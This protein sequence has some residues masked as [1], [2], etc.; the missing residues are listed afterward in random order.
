MSWKPRSMCPLDC[1]FPYRRSAGG[2]CVRQGASGLVSPQHPTMSSTP[3][4][5][6]L[7]ILTKETDAEEIHAPCVRLRTGHLLSP[8]LAPICASQKS[9]S[10]F[11]LTKRERDVLA[12]VAAGRRT[13]H[14][15][16][17]VQSPSPLSTHISNASGT[18][19]EPAGSRAQNLA[20]RWES[21]RRIPAIRSE[22][23]DGPSNH[24]A[25]NKY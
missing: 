20:H 21:D 11:A 10:A 9:T 16:A 23:G 4:L 15:L 5:P 8:T 7:P 14:R 17:A 22:R 3:S 6:E 24:E 18:R 19:R 12:L 13:R 25:P 1:T 2:L